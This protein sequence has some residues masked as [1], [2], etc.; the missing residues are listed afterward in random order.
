MVVAKSVPKYDCIVLHSVNTLKQAVDLLG[1]YSVVHSF[2][3]ND[4]AGRR[5]GDN[6]KILFLDKSERF[7]NNEDIYKP[8]NSLVDILFSKYGRPDELNL[9]IDLVNQETG[10]LRTVA[11][12]KIGAKYI[13]IHAINWNNPSGDMFNT[14]LKL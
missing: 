11:Y 14:H 7:V 3:D 2:M 10:Q 8:I 4:D 12:W 9:G 13:Y 1:R 5:C 6:M